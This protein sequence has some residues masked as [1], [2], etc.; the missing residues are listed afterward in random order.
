MDV[1]AAHVFVAVAEELSFTR[2]AARLGVSTPSVSETIRN[3]ER[4]VQQ[5]LFARTTRS[6]E[7]TPSGRALLAPA[8]ALVEAHSDV[9]HEIERLREHDELVVGSF[10]GLG[11]SL[12]RQVGEALAAARERTL[13]TVSVV[14]WSDPTCGLRTRQSEAAILVGPTSIDARLTR[15]PLGRQRRMALLP[16]DEV[17]ADLDTVCLEDVDRLGWVPV[18]VGDDVWDAA[19][20]LDDL[21]GGPPRFNGEVQSSIEGMIAAIR[22]GDGATVTIELFSELYAPAGVRMVP[23]RHVP[24]LPVDL[25]FRGP[26]SAQR[27]ARLVDLATR[28]SP[29]PSWF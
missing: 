23:M 20:R 9:S 18:D 6:V 26:R 24:S 1:R 17:P 8:T 28:L 16:E 5:S 7:L 14:D 2:A 10:Y 21:R 11:S 3:L 19:W 29:P 27:I 22:A 13:L 25:C 15:V 12:L 4:E